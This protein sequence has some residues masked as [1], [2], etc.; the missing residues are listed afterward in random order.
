[1]I[2]IGNWQKAAAIALGLCPQIAMADNT[3]PNE[4]LVRVNDIIADIRAAQRIESA[5]RLR[6]LSKEVASA[7]CHLHNGVM[8]DQSIALLVEAR[9][10]FPLLLTSLRDGNEEIGILGEETN[11]RILDH[12]TSIES[13]WMPVDDALAELMEAP[14]SADAVSRVTTV[15]EILAEMTH[16]LLSDVSGTYTN[17][18]ELTQINALLLDIAGRQSMLTQ[19]IARDACTVWGGDRSDDAIAAL[20]KSADTFELGINALINGMPELGIIPAPTP[21]IE[22]A[23][24]D[25]LSD[26]SIVKTDVDAIVAG[27]VVDD[28]KAD[29]F[30]RLNKK[31]YN[32]DKIVHLYAVFAKP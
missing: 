17:P 6:T 9:E 10:Q 29:L 26:W 2:Q 31:M 7:V 32:I 15:N 8:T 12:V 1:M 18:A 21:E 16:L 25:S 19:K 11:P 4:N 30:E 14:D 22:A 27:D 5:D 13:I 24:Q 23:L 20:K 3:T 28:V